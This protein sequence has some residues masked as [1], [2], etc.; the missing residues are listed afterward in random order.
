MLLHEKKEIAMNV[1]DR[2]KKHLWRL[3]R[4]QLT[5]IA[6]KTNGRPAILLLDMLKCV[7]LSP[8]AVIRSDRQ[9]LEA[10]LREL[11]VVGWN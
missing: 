8:I 11:A 5:D 4:V 7:S 6:L 9:V 10:A 3:C 2:I 1:Y